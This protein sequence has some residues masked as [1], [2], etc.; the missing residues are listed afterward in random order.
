[1]VFSCL[2]FPASGLPTRTIQQLT[3]QASGL[4]PAFWAGRVGATSVVKPQSTRLRL[5]VRPQIITEA[6]APQSG[7]S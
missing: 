7:N 6:K 5:R 3:T 1:M 2:P 4:I